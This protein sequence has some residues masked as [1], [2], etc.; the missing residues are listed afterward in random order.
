MKSSNLTRRLI[1]FFGYL[2][3]YLPIAFTILFSFNDS[4]IITSWSG[5]SLKWY[6]Q[7]FE[8]TQMLK[9]FW[10]SIKA[11]CF[12]ATISVFIGT[13]TAFII[14][15]H[16]NWKGRIYLNSFMTIPLIIPDVIFGLALMLM[17]V[18]LEQ[19]I[20]WPNGRG[21]ITLTFAHAAISV[22]YVV[23]VVRERLLYMDKSLEESALDLGATPLNVFLKITVPIIRHSLIAGWFLA[24]TLSFD[25]V[26]IASFV[27]GAGSTTL[28]MVVFS[29]IRLGI[30]PEINAL[31]SILV[32][33][34]TIG[35]IMSG[36]LL[37]RRNK[38]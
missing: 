35:V 33:V 27:S 34:V 20:G 16:V 26:I 31:A 1:L 22:S 8:N 21:L 11:A 6:Y 32:T 9:A 12:S 30:S 37:R 25:D 14:V 17:F 10:V 36:I 23:I 29:S 4:K 38:I 5:F 2:F 24:F 13:I 3:L 28:P 18:G 15:R 19:V 7:L